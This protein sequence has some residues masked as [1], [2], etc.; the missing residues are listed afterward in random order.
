[1]KSLH[2]VRVLVI[3]DETPI[4]LMIEDMLQDMGCIV[5]GSA[6]TVNEALGCVEAGGFDFALLDVNLAG[7][8]AEA[9]A[10]ALVR[11]GIPFAFASG[12]GRPGV[13]ERLQARPVLGKP[14]NSAELRKILCD[15]LAD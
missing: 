12:Y 2:G 15:N 10:D 11:S 1:M 7:A 4:A 14:F 9:V 6:A 8:S 13:P 3:E 5:A